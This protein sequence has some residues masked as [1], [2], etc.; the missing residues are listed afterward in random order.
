MPEIKPERVV[1]V[2][3]PA[4]AP[5]LIA[6]FSEGKPIKMTLPVETAQVGCVIV[7]IEGVAGVSGCKFIV[8]AADAD[9]MHPTELVTV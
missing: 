3:E 6:Q 8:I 9:E 2:P 4:I 7:D 1:L 5:G